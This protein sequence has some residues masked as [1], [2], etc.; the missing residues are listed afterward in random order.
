[1]VAVELLIIFL[2]IHS[3]SCGTLLQIKDVNNCLFISLRFN[4]SPSDV[5]PSNEANDYNHD[6]AHHFLPAYYEAIPGT[7]HD[8]DPSFN[9][10]QNDTSTQ[11]DMKLYGKIKKRL[12]S[13][14]FAYL[15]F[16][17]KIFGYFGK[18]SFT[19]KVY[20]FTLSILDWERNLLAFMKSL[21]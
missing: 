4:F 14:Y 19:L 1:M 20:K 12:F 17:C 3:L 16:W 8:K 9:N 18:K 15:V 7:S 5:H 6:F 11:P 13:L 10:G 21:K 2:M